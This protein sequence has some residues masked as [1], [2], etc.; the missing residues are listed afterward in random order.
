[1]SVPDQAAESMY[2]RLINT[3]PGMAYRC[4]HD[5]DW[6]LEYVSEGALG[7]LGYT[8]DELVKERQ[9]AVSDLV[10]PDDLAKVSLDVE[11]ALSAGEPFGSIYRMRKRDGEIRWISEVGRGVFGENGDLEAIEGFLSDVTAEVEGR[12]ASRAAERRAVVS[13]MASGIA[14][15]FNNILAG[16]LHAAE[17]IQ[18]EVEAASPEQRVI[19]ED[20]AGVFQ[21]VDRASALTR[22]LL[23]F[24]K[25]A[26]PAEVP[27]DLCVALPVIG[28]LLERV[29]AAAVTIE[30]S[31][32]AAPVLCRIDPV[33]LE[34]IVLNLAVN[35]SDA[36][37]SGGALRV[38]LAEPGPEAV[39]LSV[40]DT[41]VGMDDG[42][43]QRIFEP[44]FTTKSANRGTGLGLATVRSIVEGVGGRISVR[45]T[46]G[47]GT[48]FDISLPSLAPGA[49]GD[50]A[51][52]GTEVILLVDDDDIVRK[53]LARGLRRLGYTVLEAA[54]GVQAL[55][56]SERH[57]GALDLLLTDTHMPRMGGIELAGDLQQQRPDIATALLTGDNAVGPAGLFDLEIRK[58]LT[59][60][61]VAARVRTL[62][63]GR[64][65]DA[66]ATQGTPRG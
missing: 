50:K 63:D 20:L 57:K 52:F 13:R 41:G 47:E 64:A 45:S 44:Y 27:I 49:A 53:G 39:V 2:G 38:T 34:Q 12:E 1:M 16:V 10:H 4:L 9:I 24:G 15:D 11:R 56:L 46:P 48:T 21:L 6:T 40:S 3:F 60:A 29:T 26:P 37:P 62:L 65:A 22:Q 43:V 32:P 30:V 36:M 66:T 31:T 59:A 23:D 58:P 42:E 33:Q 61:A 8:A 17:S 55:K 54:D 5:A 7:L 25:P 19:R 35:A 51:G 14:H 18:A 28:T